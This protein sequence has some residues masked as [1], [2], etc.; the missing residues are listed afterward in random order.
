[1]DTQQHMKKLREDSGHIVY[2]DKLTDFLYELLRDHLSAGEV[3]QILIH[4]LQDH[5][6]CPVNFTNGWLAEYAHH[7]AEKLTNE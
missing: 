4:V 3:E 7:V 2:N 1:M 6:N 5:E